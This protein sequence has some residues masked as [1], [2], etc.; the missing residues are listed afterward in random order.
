MFKNHIHPHNIASHHILTLHLG[1]V[2]RVKIHIKEIT[3]QNQDRNQE[4]D[5]EAPVNE[6]VVEGKAIM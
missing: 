3:F 4:S 1:L 6:V 2:A 5:K